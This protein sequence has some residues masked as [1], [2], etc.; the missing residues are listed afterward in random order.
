MPGAVAASSTP[1]VQSD[2]RGSTFNISARTM[3]W[4]SLF[5]KKDSMAGIKN[6][7]V[8]NTS[9][10][11]FVCLPIEKMFRDASLHSVRVAIMILIVIHCAPNDFVRF[12][13]TIN[14]S[15][16]AGIFFARQNLVSQKIMFKTIDIGSGAV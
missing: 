10:F 15:Y 1:Q 8:E 12:L 14:M 9:G 5:G 4:P 16:F 13:A 2:F 7:L 11:C 6:P 3:Q